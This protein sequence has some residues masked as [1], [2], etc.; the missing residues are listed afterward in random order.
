MGSLFSRIVEELQILN[1]RTRLRGK[2]EH[3]LFVQFAEV[4]QEALRR[5][6]VGERQVAEGLIVAR[7]GMLIND[8]VGE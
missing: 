4:V 2:G 7:I 6:F 3:N 8:V 5:R 1:S